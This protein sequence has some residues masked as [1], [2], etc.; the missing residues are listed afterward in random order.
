MSDPVIRPISLLPWLSKEGKLGAQISSFAPLFLS[1][2]ITHSREDNATNQP[3][4]FHNC[5]IQV[6]KCTNAKFDIFHGDGSDSQG[7]IHEA[8]ALKLGRYYHLVC[9]F[10]GRATTATPFLKFF[11]SRS[12]KSSEAGRE[13]EEG[14]LSHPKDSHWNMAWQGISEVR[15]MAPP[16]HVVPVTMLCMKLAAVWYTQ[17][18]KPPT[19]NRGES[20]CG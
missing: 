20:V 19:A 10:R 6:H 13:M 4:A 5:K 16:S 11:L 17:Q 14:G 1:A 7:E 3:I 2:G 15:Y 9:R 8:F 18:L 12:G